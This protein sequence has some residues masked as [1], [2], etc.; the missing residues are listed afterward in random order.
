MEEST[1]MGNYRVEAKSV[2]V[3][4]SRPADNINI[5]QLQA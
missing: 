5:L 4:V 3:S 2:R 1:L